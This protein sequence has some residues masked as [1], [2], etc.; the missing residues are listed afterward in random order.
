MPDTNMLTTAFPAILASSV[1]DIKNSLTT[2]RVMLSQLESTYQDKKPREFNQLEFETNRMNNSLMQLL[3]LYKIG[4]SKFNL[5]IDQHSTSE[6]LEDV[7]AQQSTLLSLSNIQLTTECQSD[8]FCYCDSTL[9]SNALS[10]LV[11]NA[12]RYCLGKIM[13]SST[14]ENEYIV[15]CI[16]DDGNGYPE[17]LISSEYKQLPGIDWA[18][19]NTGLGLFF[20]DTIAQLHIQADKQGYITTDN[21]SRLGGA[22]FKLYLP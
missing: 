1:H 17:N 5:T 7:I 8:L 9:I 10:T 12:Q 11:N 16:E 14:Q 19:G 21:N 6:I 22:R 2:L 4:L 15:F 18:T 3:T 13:L 20:V